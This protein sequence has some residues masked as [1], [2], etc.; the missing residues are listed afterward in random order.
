MSGFLITVQEREQLKKELRILE[1]KYL[2]LSSKNKGNKLAERVSTA[3]IV[4]SD[5]KP[6]VFT[7]IKKDF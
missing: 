1:N 4:I 5:W 3:F 7:A 2:E 6:S